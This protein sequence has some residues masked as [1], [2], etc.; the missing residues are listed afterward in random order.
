MASGRALPIRHGESEARRAGIYVR[1]SKDRKGDLLGVTRQEDDCRALAAESGW[2]V[3][4]LYVDDDLSAYKGKRPPGSE[5][6]LSLADG[7][8]RAVDLS[9]LR[10]PAPTQALP[11]A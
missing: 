7:D 11:A 10:A 8:R 3:V 4:D 6:E 1:I 5:R 2:E 9:C